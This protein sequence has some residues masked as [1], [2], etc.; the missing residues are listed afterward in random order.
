MLEASAPPPVACDWEPVIRHNQVANLRR[1]IP[2]ADQAELLRRLTDEPEENVLTRLW[3]AQECLSK[4]GH[5]GPGPLVVQGAYEQGWVLL[6]AGTDG[7]ASSILHLD[8][9]ERPV[10]VAILAR[11]T[12]CE[13]T[14]NI[15][16]S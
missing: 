5:I 14:T 13:A 1:I 4:T 7:I 8:G 11:E 16:T 2:W 12:P 9:E 10:A 3:T 6:R 15:S